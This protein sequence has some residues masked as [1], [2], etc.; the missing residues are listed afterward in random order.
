[1][2]IYITY[3][4]IPELVALTPAQRK[5][6]YRCALTA[7]FADNP[8][9]MQVCTLIML[10]SILPGLLA[11]WLV[12]AQIG[13]NGPAWWQTKWF[14]MALSGVV[15]AVIGNTIGNQ[16]LTARLR[17]YLRRVLD[18]RS[19]ELAQISATSKI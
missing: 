10:G 9:S 4:R 12:A 2:K 6:V 18:K 15:A 14:A 11:G 17:P 5:L 7:F 19:D 16:W 13:L 3:R 8:S 1:M